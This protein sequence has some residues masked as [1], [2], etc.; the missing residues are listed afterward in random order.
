MNEAFQPQADEECPVAPIACRMPSHSS[1]GCREDGL[2]YSRQ[3]SSG[4]CQSA[5]HAARRIRP[6]NSKI[7]A[8][9]HVIRGHNSEQSSMSPAAKDGSRDSRHALPTSRE[10]PPSRIRQSSW[11]S[12]ADGSPHHQLI[13]RHTSPIAGRRTPLAGFATQHRAGKDRP[14][15]EPSG[16]HDS[17]D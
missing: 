9:V 13:L 17:I 4:V 6:R 2:H 3:A 15:P 10:P 14:S 7:S 1:R 8:R 11:H 5:S 12:K 16:W